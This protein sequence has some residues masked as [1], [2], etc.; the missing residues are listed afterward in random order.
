MNTPTPNN[1]PSKISPTISSSSAPE[2]VSTGTEDSRSQENSIADKNGEGCDEN[3]APSTDDVNTVDSRE[4]EEPI[5]SEPPSTTTPE[6]SGDNVGNED[7]VDN[8]GN[9]DMSDSKESEEKGESMSAQGHYAWA[10]RAEPLYVPPKGGESGAYPFTPEPHVEPRE[11]YAQDAHSAGKE[12]SV[13]YVDNFGRTVYSS[14]IV[15][16]DDGAVVTFVDNN[17]DISRTNWPSFLHET[18]AQR[19]GAIVAFVLMAVIPSFVFSLYYL[20][21]LDKAVKRDKFSAVLHWIILFTSVM[22]VGAKVAFAP[23]AW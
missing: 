1:M 21:I 2:V 16:Q 13:A 23:L 20:F 8:G 15:E 19:L 3:V 22:F 17:T 4:N 6:D 18:T 10:H 14:N 12:E 11:E 7:S 5:M 9:E